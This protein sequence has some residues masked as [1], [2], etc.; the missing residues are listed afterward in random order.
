MQ[1]IPDYL[2]TSITRKKRN[3]ETNDLV[4]RIIDE[5]QPKT[6][7]DIQ[8]ALKDISDHSSN[9]CLT[10]NSKITWVMKIMSAAPKKAITGE[11]VTPRRP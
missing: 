9:L 6:A 2:E 10:P 5:Y 1:T 3:K 11:T 8:E 7:Q 4:S